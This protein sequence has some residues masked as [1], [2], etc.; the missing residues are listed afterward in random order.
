M[1]PDYEIRKP[2]GHFWKKRRAREN[3]IGWEK[4]MVLAEIGSSGVGCSDTGVYTDFW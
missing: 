4:M 1:I 3:P 2:Q